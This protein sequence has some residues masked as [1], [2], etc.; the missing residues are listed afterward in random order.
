MNSTDQIQRTLE[1][2]LGL[3]R[4]WQ[5]VSTPEGLSSWFSQRVTFDVQ[6]GAEIIFDWDNHGKKYGEVEILEPQTRFGFRWLAGE[7]DLVEPLTSA[8]ST[9]VVFELE[10]TA[11]GTRLTVTETGFSQLSKE[12]QK[13]EKVKNE[14]GWDFELPE[15]KNFL[16]G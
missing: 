5:A 7:P 1:L 14:Q 16:E 4:T 15:L 13:P 11:S 8:N 12:L 9:L 3:L 10:E 2:P 6:M